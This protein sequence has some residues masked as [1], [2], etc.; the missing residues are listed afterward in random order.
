M[1]KFTIYNPT[2][3]EITCIF[4]GREDD[5]A[6]NGSYI[7]GE[8][9]AKEYTIVNGQAVRKNDALRTATGKGIVGVESATAWT[10]M[11][12]RI[13]ACCPSSDWR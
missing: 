10:V 6:L 12:A 8:Y 9:S 4:E 1:T 11:Q 7:E 5:A 2:T 13:V 3:S